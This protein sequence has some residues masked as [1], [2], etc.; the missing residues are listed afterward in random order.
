[1]RVHIQN[2]YEA[3]LSEKVHKVYGQLGD[4]IIDQ[5][6]RHEKALKS[7]RHAYIAKFKNAIHVLDSHYRV[8]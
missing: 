2:D 5:Q 4:R 3:K 1:V 6:K 8:R 7:T